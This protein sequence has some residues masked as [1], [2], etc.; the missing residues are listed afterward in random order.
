M[1]EIFIFRKRS[2][3]MSFQ[4]TKYCPRNETDWNQ[5]FSAI[6]CTKDNGY[7]CLPNENITELLEFCYKYPFI[8]IQEDRLYDYW[9]ESISS[10]LKYVTHKIFKLCRNVLADSFLLKKKMETF[11]KKCTIAVK[12]MSYLIYQTERLKFAIFIYMLLGK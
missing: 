10:I 2:R 11:L 3:V 5:R 7:M 1:T 4:F 6:N 8:L 9:N 12:C